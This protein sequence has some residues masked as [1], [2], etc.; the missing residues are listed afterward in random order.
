MS[1]WCQDILQVEYSTRNCAKR[2]NRQLTKRNLQSARKEGIFKDAM[3]KDFC[4]C[5]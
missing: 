2:K 4:E 1:L 5:C 3:A